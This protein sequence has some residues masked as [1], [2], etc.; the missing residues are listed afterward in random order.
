MAHPAMPT[1]AR[2]PED[3]KAPCPRRYTRVSCPRVYR[4]FLAFAARVF[5]TEAERG[6][7]V[8]FFLVVDFLLVVVERVLLFVDFLLRLAAIPILIP[9]LY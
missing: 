1:P 9:V 6:L 2:D 8:L 3:K 7:A 5:L 4:L